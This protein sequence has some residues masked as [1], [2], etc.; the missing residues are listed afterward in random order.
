MASSVC[1][2]LG[3]RC[4]LLLF[5]QCEGDYAKLAAFLHVEE[6]IAAQRILRVCRKARIR[7]KQRQD[8]K[9][10]A[11]LLSA[12]LEEVDHILAQS[13]IWRREYQKRKAALAAD[14][15]RDPMF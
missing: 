11:V 5:V 1:P 8:T 2:T 4:A 6:R 15:M 10:L 3:E 12:W 14:P 9:A 7:S 13:E